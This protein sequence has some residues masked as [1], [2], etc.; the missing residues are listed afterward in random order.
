MQM[1]TIGLEFR[2]KPRRPSRRVKVA[3]KLS[4]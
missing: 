1:T 3:I 4:Q 2:D